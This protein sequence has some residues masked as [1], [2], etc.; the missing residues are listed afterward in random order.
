MISVM[1]IDLEIYY[2][3]LQ[4]AKA[5]CN[6]EYIEVNPANQLCQKTL[7]EVNKVSILFHRASS[8]LFRYRYKPYN[9]SAKINNL[10][11]YDQL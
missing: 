7:A 9:S 3:Y 5:R 6:G 8:N 1:I 4:T 2:G 11:E 10:V